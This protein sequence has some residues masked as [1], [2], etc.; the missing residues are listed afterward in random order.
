MRLAAFIAAA[1]AAATPGTLARA[2]PPRECSAI[3][4]P[5]LEEGR[6]FAKG[7]PYA[8][9]MR[10]FAAGRD[11]KAADDLRTAWYKVRA[12]LAKVFAT[13]QCAEGGIQAT[14]GRRVFANPPQAVPA[15]DRFLPPRTVAIA[16]AVGLCATGDPDGAAAWLAENVAADDA[17]ARTAAVVLWAASGRVEAARALIPPHARGSA[18]DAARKAVGTREERAGVNLDGPRKE[19]IP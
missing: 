13:D 4:R 10:S 1:L 8:A 9:G 3:P 15:E 16:V 19:A 11:A 12:D 14:L 5:S 17:P 2:A 18:W 6:P 7:G